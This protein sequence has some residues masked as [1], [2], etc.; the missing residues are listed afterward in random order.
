MFYY[1]DDLRKPLEIQ[2]VVYSFTA[3]TGTI[4]YSSILMTFVK[5]LEIQHFSCTHLLLDGFGSW[6]STDDYS[7]DLHEPIRNP[8]FVCITLLP[9]GFGRHS[10]YSTILATFTNLLSM[11]NQTLF[12]YELAP[13]RLWRAFWKPSQTY[14]KSNMFPLR[15]C[16]WTAVATT[17]SRF[18]YSHD[19]RRPFGNPT[20]FYEFARRRN[21]QARAHTLSFRRPS[22]TYSKSDTCL[23]SICSRTALAARAHS[24]LFWRPLQIY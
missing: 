18:H 9:D 13:G 4:P 20:S 14:Q 3:S 21:W 6:G 16:S 11:R 7:D 10:S 15:T 5:V 12:V 1:S 8:I 17:G 23:L 19:L 24:T 22:Q 2:Y